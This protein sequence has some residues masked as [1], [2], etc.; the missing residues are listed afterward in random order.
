MAYETLVEGIADLGLAYL[1]ILADP[2][3]DLIIDLRKRF[4]GAVVAELGLRRGHPARRR[5][6]D[7]RGGPRRLV[8]VGREYLANPDLA[9]RWR[10]GADLNE[11][12]AAT[13]Y[14][15]GAEGYTDYPSLAG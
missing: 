6:V 13:F 12:D 7:S 2:S 8:A 9:E 11:P 3:A 4:G 5:R 10:T 14:G 15:G 1:S